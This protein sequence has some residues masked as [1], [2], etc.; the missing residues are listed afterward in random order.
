MF[1]AKSLSDLVNESLNLNDCDQIATKSEVKVKVTES[2]DENDD[3]DETI[4]SSPDD[5][6]EGARSLSPED[7]KVKVKKKKVKKKSKV[8]HKDKVVVSGPPTD[9]LISISTNMNSHL[10]TL[11]VSIE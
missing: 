11:L 5:L 7:E 6:V 4:S 1:P 3:E 9:K 2:E 10:T 8:R